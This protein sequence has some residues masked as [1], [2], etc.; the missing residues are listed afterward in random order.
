MAK[1]IDIGD[2]K[3]GQGAPLVLIAGPCV[4]EDYETTRQI[5]GQLKET[6]D[7]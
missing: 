4:S 6:T 3:V 2:I 7:K 5:A 1:P